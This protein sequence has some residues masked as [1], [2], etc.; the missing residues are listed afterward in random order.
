[1][2]ATS[3][4]TIPQLHN[5]VTPPPGLELP[6]VW[7]SESRPLFVSLPPNPTTVDNKVV[8]KGFKKPYLSFLPNLFLV[9]SLSF[10][11]VERNI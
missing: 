11:L 10:G 4:Q 6:W 9:L 7:G 5:V 3:S 1:M 8:N 2:V